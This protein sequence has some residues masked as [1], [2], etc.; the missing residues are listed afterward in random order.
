MMLCYVAGYRD[1]ITVALSRLALELGAAQEVFVPLA[2]VHW[3]VQ[4]F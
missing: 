1:A 4:P 2:G 3:R